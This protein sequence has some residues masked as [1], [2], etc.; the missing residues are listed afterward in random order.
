MDWIIRSI[1]I[2]NVV[3]REVSWKLEQKECVGEREKKERE[4]RWEG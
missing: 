1:I 4:E 2:K 3:Y